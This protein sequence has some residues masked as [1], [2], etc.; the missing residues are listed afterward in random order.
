LLRW[1]KVEKGENPGEGVM[2]LGRRVRSSLIEFSLNR[3]E[4]GREEV[5]SL[6]KQKALASA[7]LVRVGEREL[8]G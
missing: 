1:S 8:R 4:L 5:D 6:E 3:R 2:A 7:L